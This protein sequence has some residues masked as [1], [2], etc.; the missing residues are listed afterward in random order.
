MMQKLK[1]GGLLLASLFFISSS[2]NYRSGGGLT[3]GFFLC[4]DGEVAVPRGGAVACAGSLDELHVASGS[5]SSCSESAVGE[6]DGWIRSGC[7]VNGET[8]SGRQEA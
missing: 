4:V 6:A 7:C 2:Q 3:V 8:T 5:T 1:K